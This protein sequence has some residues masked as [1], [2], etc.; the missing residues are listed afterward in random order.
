MDANLAI[1]YGK[2]GKTG[3]KLSAFILKASVQ[4]KTLFYHVEFMNRAPSSVDN[5]LSKVNN[6]SSIL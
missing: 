6:L 2:L 1:W 4:D 5:S 3:I